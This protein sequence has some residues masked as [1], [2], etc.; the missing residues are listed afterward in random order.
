MTKRRRRKRLGDGKS[1]GG[2]YGR[3]TKIM[4]QKLGDHYGLAIQQTNSVVK[5]N[6]EFFQ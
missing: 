3:M 1:Y 2:G 4:E 5:S 6:V